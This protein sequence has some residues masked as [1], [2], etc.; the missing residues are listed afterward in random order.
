VNERRE[1]PRTKANSD[2]A[3][4]DIHGNVGALSIVSSVSGALLEQSSNYAHVF[5]VLRRMFPRLQGFDC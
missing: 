1:R 4:P 5:L 3:S 2:Q